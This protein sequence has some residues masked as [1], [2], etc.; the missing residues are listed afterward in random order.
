MIKIEFS[1]GI[2]LYIFVTAGLIVVLWAFFEKKKKWSGFLSWDKRFFWQC[3]TCM[4]V[5]VDSKHANISKC[6]RCGSYNKKERD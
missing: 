6:P 2:A 4:Y 1:L 5:Y 3:D